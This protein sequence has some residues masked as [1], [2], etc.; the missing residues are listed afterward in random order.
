MP[1][2]GSTTKEKMGQL[3]QIQELTNGISDKYFEFQHWLSQ[4]AAED[5][6]IASSKNSASQK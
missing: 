3:T 6:G 1:L 4:E 2:E 5:L